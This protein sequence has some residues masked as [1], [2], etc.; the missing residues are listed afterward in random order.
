MEIQEL[1][2]R[3]KELEKEKEENKKIIKILNEMVD[4]LTIKLEIEEAD[5]KYNQEEASEETIPKY[6]IRDKIKEYN[7][8]RKKAETKEIN[9][10]FV[11]YI[12]ILEELL[13]E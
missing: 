3:I 1:K 9:D 12:D 6:I 5:N 4:E 11:N 10:M 7:E 8:Q 13:G 2:N